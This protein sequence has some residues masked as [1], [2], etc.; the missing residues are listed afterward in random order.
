ME[1]TQN[2]SDSYGR[3]ED[4]DDQQINT[5]FRTDKYKCYIGDPSPKPLVPVKSD[6]LLQ[7]LQITPPCH[8]QQIVPNTNEINEPHIN[9]TYDVISGGADGKVVKIKPRVPP[10]T[11]SIKRAQVHSKPLIPPSNI[12]KELSHVKPAS[13]EQQSESITNVENEP[14]TKKSYDVI[15]G[16]KSV[17]IKPKIPLK[18]E[19][20]KRAPVNSKPN[21]VIES[22]GH[23]KPT[24]CE[25]QSVSITNTNNESHTNK[26]HGVI[27]DGADVIAAK[28]KPKIP[29]KTE[30][31]KRLSFHSKPKVLLKTPCNVTTNNGQKDV[32]PECDSIIMTSGGLGEMELG[33]IDQNK[34]YSTVVRPTKKESN[35]EAIP[36]TQTR[37]EYSKVGCDDENVDMTSRT[38]CQKDLNDLYVSVEHIRNKKSS[39]K[40]RYST[41]SEV[42]YTD[43][44][45]R[46]EILTDMAKLPIDQISMYASVVR[47]TNQVKSSNEPSDDGDVYSEVELT[48]ID[49]RPDTPSE[50]TCPIDENDTYATISD[51]DTNKGEESSEA[52]IPKQHCDIYA[53]VKRNIKNAET[54]N[55]TICPIYQNYATVSD[56]DTNEGELCC[57]A[58]IPKQNCDVSEVKRTKEDAMAMVGTTCTTDQRFPHATFVR[59]ESKIKRF[60]RKITSKSTKD[61]AEDLTDKSDRSKNVEET[62]ET[63]SVDMVKNTTYIS[64]LNTG[65]DIRIFL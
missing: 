39:N 55:G 24:N 10:K 54:I 12:R 15:S 53:E 34:L 14:Q 44:D 31:L 64:V 58:M 28:L 8:D 50:K 59:K 63:I 25:Q 38:I 65:K 9:K 56:D 45:V 16:G 43:N 27:F 33:L 4:I 3:R 37:D 6:Q 13:R 20:I 29:P 5:T 60:I 48:D 40:E 26:R 57:E 32:F 22:F 52:L 35:T 30:S 36:H 2:I 17:K 51:D 41:F 47:H 18:T 23:V 62:E 46:P 42:E 19:S 21:N 61:H 7:N 49:V 1:T 11:E